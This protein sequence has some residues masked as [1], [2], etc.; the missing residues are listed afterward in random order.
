MN[1]ISYALVAVSIL[2]GLF[3]SWQFQDVVRQANNNKGP[4]PAAE[5]VAGESAGNVPVQVVRVEWP[6]PPKPVEEKEKKPAAKAV[7]KQT[8]TVKKNGKGGGGKG[9]GLQVVGVFECEMEFY[10]EV[11]RSHGAKVIVF[12]QSKKQFF[13]LTYGGDVR[14]MEKLGSDFSPVSRRITDDYPDSQKLLERVRKTWGPGQYDILLLQPMQLANRIQNE[15]QTQLSIVNAKNA[16]VVFISY[17][18]ANDKLH[19]MI[20][21]A[22]LNGKEVYIRSSIYL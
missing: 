15:I 19:I 18:K 11:M 3:L 8:D 22:V 21:K 17:T 14:P 10:L 2:L 20:K 5:Q 6:D 12:E 16:Q 13:E 9:G 7:K 1:R 4:A